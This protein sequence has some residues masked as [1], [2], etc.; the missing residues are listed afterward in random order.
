MRNLDSSNPPP[1][2]AAARR[3]AA[4]RLGEAGVAGPELDARLLVEAATGRDYAGL[5][6]DADARLT[7]EEAALLEAMLARRA[8]R[9]PLDHI[10]GVKRF[11]TLELEVS[12][13]VLSPRPETEALVEAA[14]EALPLDAETRVLDLGTGS[15]AAL[16]AVLSERPR[17]WGLG[18]DRSADALAMAR[19]NA[20]RAGL[21]GRAAF[22][23][24]DWGRALEAGFDVVVSNPPYVESAEIAALDEEVRRYEPHAALDGGADG[25][26]AYREIARHGWRLV[27]PDG[28]A[29][30]EVG[31]GQDADVYNVFAG[32]GGFEPLPPR[33]DLAG[34]ARIVRLRRASS[35]QA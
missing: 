4:R 29:A 30:F 32:A 14:L 35:D 11:W 34:R 2:I 26:D 18:V 23:Q 19:R 27:K 31:A 7:P 5:V 16:L 13:A 12:P 33:R 1:T 15:G 24:G 3:A 10:L 22:V 28:L 8:A 25:L 20:S 9:E 17:A 6:A 21:A